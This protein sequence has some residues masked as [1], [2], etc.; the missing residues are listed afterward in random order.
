MTFP[1]FQRFRLKIA[2]AAIGVVAPALHGPVAF[3]QSPALINVSTRGTAGAGDNVMIAG[4][5]I[6]GTASR[7]IAIRVTGPSLTQYGVSGVL[8]DPTLTLNSGGTDLAT[9]DD[10]QTDAASAAALRNVN[11]AP[12]SDREAA[13]VRTLA[14]GGYT[15]VVGG[16]G[17]GTGVALI[18]VFDLDADSN[19]SSRVVNLSTRGRVGSGDNVMIMGFI[20]SGGAARDVLVTAIGGSLAEYGVSGVLADPKIEVYSGSS[21]IAESDDWLDSK[22]FISIA[23]TGASPRDPYESAVLLHL[24][25]GGYTVVVS[26]VDGSQGVALPEVYEIPSLRNIAFA[27]ATL[28]GRTGK[29]VI[30]P[31]SDTLDFN[32]TSAG[33]ATV[34]AGTPGTY[35]Y[36]LQD[37]FNSAFTLDAG[38]YS[39]NGKL[40]F[41]RSGVAYFIGTLKKPGGTSQTANGILVLN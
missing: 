28:N 31:T 26:G 11:L 32:F 19:S 27:P 36:T 37:D 8:A 20:V 14:P 38:G 35:S 33:A 10:W 5:I 24:A 17:T 21:K 30:A 12:S 3:A 22:D 7:R 25:P 29:F 16:K 41:Y 23:R 9:N 2:A 1:R 4:F 40:Q 34:N 13:L 15:V 18:E 6:D 39:L